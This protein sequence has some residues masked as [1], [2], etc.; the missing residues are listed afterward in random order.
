MPKY[1]SFEIW[2]ISQNPLSVEWEWAQFWAPGGKRVY[3]SLLE[4]WQMAKHASFMPKYGNFGNQ[5]LSRKPL[6][7]E[8]KYAQFRRPG[9]ES[10]C[11]YFW[12]FGPW[13]SWLLSR[14]PRPMGLLFF[15]WPVVLELQGI[16]VKCTNW[17]QNDLEH[18]EVKG[19]TYM[20]YFCPS[21]RFHSALWPAVSELQASAPNDPKWT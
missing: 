16:W 6:P 7:I 5:P 3:V 19:I 14:A 2:P 15:L 11:D 18:C 21:A 9:I 17:P 12:N 1:D 13:P 10:V 20:Y 8:L 4:F